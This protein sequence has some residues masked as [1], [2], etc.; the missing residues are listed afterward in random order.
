MNKQLNP[1]A[2]LGFWL[3][4]AI[5]IIVSGYLFKDLADISQ[6][7]IQSE[8]TNTIWV[9]YNRNILAVIAV[10]ALAA[11]IAIKY[12]HR[13][14]VN[15][16]VMALLV[17]LFS[18][19]FFS[20][21]INPH[22]MMRERQYDGVFV[23][24]AEARKYIAPEESV[25][26]LE[27]NGQARAHADE[28]LLR[29]HIAGNGTIGGENVVMTYCGLTNLGMAVTPEINGKA[30][31]LRPMTQLENNLV[32]ADRNTNEP[33]QQ[34]WMQKENDVNAN[35][36]ARMKEWPTFRMPFAK[37]AEAYPEGEVF[38]ND[39]LI[40]DMKPGFLGNP[41]LAVYDPLMDMIFDHAISD[42]AISV[43]P[44]FPTIKHRDDRLPTKEKVWAFNIGDDYVA[45][46]EEFVRNH[47]NMINTKVG[48]VDVII[49]YDEK[50]ESLGIF[51]NTTGTTIEA[52][53]FYGLTEA[54]KME[55]VETV[56]AGA[57]WI[58]WANFFPDTDI[59]RN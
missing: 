29:P 23:S 1:M 3:N 14:I 10:L 42:Q 8:R 21:F 46:T 12:L 20:G 13:N 44:T 32:M 51:Y 5:A 53:D 56:K 39:Y 4:M 41:F 45:Y 52:I 15:N 25:I 47:N 33:I 40:D 36:D 55:R 7:I 35:N 34:L 57:Y 30:L 58:V 48:G 59:N 6:W 31:N 27:I 24:V 54:G 18:F 50:M 17:V 11:S 2:H 43:E 38:V 9:W 37:F 49:A 16:K 19:Q 26:V 22:M 28:Q